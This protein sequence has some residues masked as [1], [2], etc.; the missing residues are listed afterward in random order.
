MIHPITDPLN[1]CWRL[2]L[3]L[4]CSPY[5]FN[6]TLLPRSYCRDGASQIKVEEWSGS[7]K[8]WDL[9]ARGRR[10]DRKLARV[11]EFRFGRRMVLDLDRLDPVFASVSP[12][13]EDLG[14]VLLTIGR[15]EYVGGWHDR[16][17]FDRSRVSNWKSRVQS[18][19]CE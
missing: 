11:L 6:A 14:I 2:H 8:K 9:C 7:G 15:R 3:C 5:F 4:F 12:S 13:L 10:Y 16:R 1:F 17:D 18:Q 19:L